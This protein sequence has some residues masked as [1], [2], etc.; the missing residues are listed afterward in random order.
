MT[1]ERGQSHG[2][3]ARA[4]FTGRAFAIA[5]AILLFFSSA[6]AAADAPIL[7]A[8]PAP[9]SY[10]PARSYPIIVS[11]VDADGHPVPDVLV[12]ASIPSGDFN[13][14]ISDL[15][16]HSQE[17]FTDSAGRMRTTLRL[18]E[19][20]TTPLFATLSAYTPYWSSTAPPQ[21]L[22]ATP[23]DEIDYTF[24]ISQPLV[25]YRVRVSDYQGGPRQGVT[26]RLT[27]PYFVLRQTDSSGL[28]SFRLPQNFS[29]GGQVEI[30]SNYESFA[31]NA[32]QDGSTQEISVPIPLRH[33]VPLN[34]TH[35][36]NWSVQIFES[37]GRPL[38]N[39]PVELGV[40]RSR[41][42][43]VSDSA[44]FV[45]FSDLPFERANLSWVIYNYTYHQE[46]ILD[47]APAVI[48]TQ[49]L[50]TM[51][52]SSPETLGDSC[53]RVNVNVTD[54][55]HH[56]L[57]Q[58]GARPVSGTNQLLFTLDKEVTL[59]G[60]LQFT[61]VLCVETDT[62][63]EVTASNPFE[64][65]VLEV[66]LKFTTQPPP[67]ASVYARPPPLEV[68]QA[69]AVSADRRK[70]EM[71]LILVYVLVVLAVIFLVTRFRGFVFYYFQSIMRFIYTTRK[72]S[73]AEEAGEPKRPRLR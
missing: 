12:M 2:A 33:P 52:A 68:I 39:Q 47:R 16:N 60:V 56:P 23:G 34:I 15:V 50:L 9:G 49:Q 73:E 48:R 24:Q 67:S 28:V 35:L 8:A 64:R 32:S 14:N 10:L 70:A 66:Q 25:T 7:L 38:S 54:P 19:N 61:R 17:G 30:G 63:F 22:P 45:H 40:G 71:L 21:S 43:Y 1:D 37:S 59:G 42:T 4:L 18:S 20:E 58:V 27:K 57:L 55:R 5:F 53:Y 26:V 31:F 41:W 11:V 51:T 69:S 13:K 36:F 46:I 29:V 6:L 3:G 44:G 65:A 62:T 72:P